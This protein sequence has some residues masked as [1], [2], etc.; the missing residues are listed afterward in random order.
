MWE[1]GGVWNFAGQVEKHRG[2]GFCST[3]TLISSIKVQKNVLSLSPTLS[4]CMRQRKASAQLHVH[5]PW[6]M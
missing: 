1:S 5:A 2:V 6:E 3:M 4:S